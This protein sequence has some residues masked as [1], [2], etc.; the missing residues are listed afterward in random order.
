MKLPSIL[1]LGLLAFTVSTDAQT[2]CGPR[3]RRNWD[4]LSDTD[5][6]TYKSALASAMD[7]GAYI[8]FVEIHQEHMSN[9]EAH[10]QCMFIYWHRYFL[11]AFEN[12][13]RAQGD[14]YACVTL[15]YYNWMDAYSRQLDGKCSSYGDCAAITSELGG[16]SGSTQTVTINSDTI[17]G[18]C[19]NEWPLNHFCQSSTPAVHNDLSA[20]MG[21]Q[22]S[23]ADPIFWSHHSMVDALHT[24]FHKCRV[25][26][27][28]MTFEEK[29]TNTVAWES[30]ARRDGGVFLP[31]DVVAV[32]TGTDTNPLNAS[33]DSLVDQ[34]FH[35][36]PNRYADLMDIR[37]LG[38]FSYSY[39]LSGQLAS[40][41]TNC[42]GSSS[43]ATNAPV[44][45]TN[46]PSPTT[47]SPV[48]T[49]TAPVPTSSLV[50]TSTVPASTTA[51]P[52]TPTNPPEPST[53]SP[54]PTTTSSPA[55]QS[56]S[57]PSL[58][59]FTDGLN[60]QQLQDAQ[61][62]F[63]WLWSNFF[64]N[65]NTPNI[66]QLV[67][68]DATTPQETKSTPAPSKGAQDDGKVD[69]IIIDECGESEQRVM[70]WYQQTATA[71]GGMSVET[72]ADIER[73]SCMFHDQCLGGV[74]DFS[75]DF[76]ARWGFKESRCKTIVEAVKCGTESIIY[77]QWRENMETHFGCPIPASVSTP[78]P[79][80]QEQISLTD[81]TQ[82]TIAQSII[83]SV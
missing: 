78:A 13:L 29:A 73:Q 16:S 33:R 58:P 54:V 31:T 15:P 74:K 71:M 3:V 5:K 68:E 80:S 4:A 83:Q 76:K 48:P 17:Q 72:I 65:N 25:G 49:T 6:N 32:R 34:F 63:Q 14:E 77:S 59:P 23:P 20:T 57:I 22:A 10:G 26:T 44:A 50:P 42:D 70:T 27:Q 51:T 62:F 52:E 19:V 28:H 60:E 1:T 38:D 79:S 35:D 40:M 64:P 41:Y 11:V 56:P 30:C 18:S 47:S 69:V 36:V 81:Q 66:R 67:A 24:I 82:Q 8:K 53:T 46:A 2:T 75:D 43:P 39:E 7:S 61:L 9:I 55:T 45:S 37:D 21:Y 12:M